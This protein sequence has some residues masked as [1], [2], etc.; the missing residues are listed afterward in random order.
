MALDAGT[1]V[2]A[3]DAVSDDADE[4]GAPIA[5]ESAAD[6]ETRK[7]RRRGRRGGRRNRRD[8]EE[9]VNERAAVQ[10][11]DG[12]MT[13]GVAQYVADEL[14]AQDAVTEVPEPAAEASDD[15]VFEPMPAAEPVAEAEVPVEKP[16]RARRKKII[17]TA[18]SAPAESAPVDATA[19]DGDEPVAEKPKRKPRARKPKAE[20]VDAAAPDAVSEAAP[21]EVTAVEEA[22]VSP[23]VEPTPEPAIAK[24]EDAPK[25]RRVKKELPAEGVVVSSS[26]GKAE[27][28]EG[29]DTEPPKKKAGWWQ[30]RLGLG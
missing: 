20:A 2:E 4:A 5:G 26:A 30:R 8:G 13:P 23:E 15:V 24:T 3:G 17:E 10:P 22:P 27:A 29:D 12:E 18:E 1:D 14:L 28:V 25:S 16:K 7:R 21:V 11:V 6:A 19:V 9:A